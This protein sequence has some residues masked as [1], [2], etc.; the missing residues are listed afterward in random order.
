VKIDGEMTAQD[1]DLTSTKLAES[2]TESMRH[3]GRCELVCHFPETID[4]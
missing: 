3:R 1:E 2:C 4:A